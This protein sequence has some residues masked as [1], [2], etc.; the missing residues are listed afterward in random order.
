MSVPWLQ[1]EQYETVLGALALLDI[2]AM[3]L[4]RALAVV[5]EWGVIR[6][7]LKEKRLRVPIALA[8]S[9]T[10]C[11]WGQFDVFSVIFRQ[12]GRVFRRILIRDVCDRGR[13]SRWKQGRDPAVPGCT[14]VRTGSR[15]RAHS[16]QVRQNCQIRGIALYRLEGRHP[17][18]G[19]AAMATLVLLALPALASDP[20]DGIRIEP[21]FTGKPCERAKNFG[22]WIDADRDGEN[23]REEVLIAESLVPTIRDSKGKL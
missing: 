7:W 5:F 19:F 3:L 22:S 10:I 1:P 2:L 23:T 4:E 9:Y 17:M 16:R 8:A 18:F 11:V 13:H 14:R 15:E 6:D 21:E 20:L 12:G